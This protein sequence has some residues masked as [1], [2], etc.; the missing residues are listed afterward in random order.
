MG[1]RPR[2]NSARSGRLSTLPALNRALA[3]VA[4]EGGS[5]RRCQGIAGQKRKEASV[6]LAELMRSD[7]TDDVEMP[8]RSYPRY[9]LLGCWICSCDEW[10]TSE[11]ANCKFRI[12]LCRQRS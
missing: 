4:S 3:P 1:E 11:I 6:E 7:Y 12:S 2:H 5:K 9:Q 8:D 10:R